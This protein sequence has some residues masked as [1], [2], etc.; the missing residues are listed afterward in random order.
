[1][2]LSLQQPHSLK[3][4][5]VL[6]P[7]FAPLFFFPFLFPTTLASPSFP[8]IFL[9]S[10]ATNDILPREFAG[11]YSSFEMHLSDPGRPPLGRGSILVGLG[12]VALIFPAMGVCH[13]PN[14]HK[15][16]KQL[17]RPSRFQFFF[18]FGG[19]PRHFASC[20][21]WSGPCHPPH[22]LLS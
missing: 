1:M 18:Y 16:N 13:V 21:F 9:H 7:S 4:R 11:R 19:P 14:H 17:R 12:H 22:R 20:P 6:P 10:P 2:S 15:Q 3:E 8:R 5:R